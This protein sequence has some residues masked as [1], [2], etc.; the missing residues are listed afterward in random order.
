MGR[1]K[2]QYSSPKRVEI[3]LVVLIPADA[4]APSEI[5]KAEIVFKLLTLAGLC[6]R[7]LL[8]PVNCNIF[9]TEERGDLR[10]D[11][12]EARSGVVGEGVIG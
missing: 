8:A 5:S 12:A 10:F 2:N 11:E 3:T 1:L 4:I 7:I 9:P 6:R